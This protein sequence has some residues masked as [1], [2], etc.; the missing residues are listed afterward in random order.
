MTAPE[1]VRMTWADIWS[2][3]YGPGQALRDRGVD[4]PTEWWVLWVVD[5]EARLLPVIPTDQYTVIGSVDTTTSP[6]SLHV[7]GAMFGDYAAAVQFPPNSG[8]EP[9]REPYAATLWA[10]D[11]DE[12]VTLAHQAVTDATPQPEPDGPGPVEP[13]P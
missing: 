12:A 9:G 13:T 5:G 2:A 3:P 7:C 11:M 8:A 4:W 6:H 1:P 10:L